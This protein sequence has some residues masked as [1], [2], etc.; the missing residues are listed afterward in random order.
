MQSSSEKLQ[1]VNSMKN[2]EHF[3]F[4]TFDTLHMEYF[5]L[6]FVKLKIFT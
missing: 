6:L 4:C 1:Y 3:T 2:H 5:D